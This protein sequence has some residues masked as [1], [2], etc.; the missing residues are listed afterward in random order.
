MNITVDIILALLGIAI[1]AWYTFKG[2]FKTLFS[3]ACLILS[4]MISSFLTPI[5]FSDAGIMEAIGYC[6]VFVIVYIILKIIIKLMDKIIK[7]L[8]VIKTANRILGFLFGVLCAY[9]I[10][11]AVSVVFSV[12]GDVYEN[13]LLC[14]FFVDYG[15]FSIAN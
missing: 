6:I 15:I 11:S 14:G 4:A 7:R 9:I 3:F 1:I 2:F 8:P 10:L 12:F 13:S 5:I